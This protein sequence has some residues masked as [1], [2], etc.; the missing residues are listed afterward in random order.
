MVQGRQSPVRQSA[1]EMP[2]QAHSEVAS[3]LTCASWAVQIGSCSNFISVVVRK[4]P[5]RKQ[6]MGERIDFSLQFQV[7]VHRFCGS[8]DRSLDSFMSHPCQEQR[9]VSTCM[10]VS[11]FRLDVSSLTHSG[12]AAYGMVSPTVG[13]V[14]L[15]Q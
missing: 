2:S 15:R 7:T 3:S 13:W 10:L 4:Y 14:S 1:L 8:Q 11:F 9:D 12:L 6:A 5:D